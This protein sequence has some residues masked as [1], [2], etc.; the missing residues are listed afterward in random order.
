MNWNLKN[1]WTMEESRSFGV[2]QVTYHSHFID[3]LIFF[4]HVLE[5]L[6]PIFFV[7]NYVFWK[8]TIIYI[9]SLIYTWM[10]FRLKKCR[11][12]QKKLLLISVYEIMCFQHKKYVS[13]IFALVSILRSTVE[14]RQHSK[15]YQCEMCS[16]TFFSH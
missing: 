10:F 4:F 16:P 11:L 2:I 8:Q 3:T 12:L 9:E 7:W 1:T 14:F 6:F 13:Q 15:T 5:V